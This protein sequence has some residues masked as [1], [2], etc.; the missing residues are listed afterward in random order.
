MSP[1]KFYIIRIV[2]IL[3][4]IQ[5]SYAQFQK[6]R[7]VELKLN[8]HNLKTEEK[9]TLLLELS[10]LY[11]SNNSKK[12][13]SLSKQA[14]E[15]AKQI[16][17]QKLI[18]NSYRAMSSYY[19]EKNDFDS[20]KYILNSA[21]KFI[22]K[23]AMCYFLLGQNQWFNGNED[24]C[25]YYY[26]LCEDECIKNNDKKTLAIACHSF[27]DYYRYNHKYDLAQKYIS[28]SI[29]ILEKINC[30]SDLATAYNIQAEIYRV[31]AIYP[32]AIKTYLQTIKIAYQIQDS[33]R[34]GYCI[35]RIGYIHYMQDEFIF[36]EV[37]LK[38]ALTISEK[39]NSKNLSLFCLKTLT[40]L[41]SNQNNAVQCK[42]YATKC[43][44]AG[45]KLKDITAQSLAYSS[46]SNL[47]FKNNKTDSSLIFANKAYHIADSSGDKINKLNSLLNKIPIFIYQKKHNTVLKLCNEGIIIAKETETLESLKDLYRYQYQTYEKL[48]NKSMAFESLLKYKM[49]E[50]STKN[51]ETNLIAK[52]SQYEL[53]YLNKHLSDTLNFIT[54]FQ[55]QE[56]R[57][58]VEKQQG[59]FILITSLLIVVTLLCIMIIIWS[60]R[61][62]QKKLNI[63]LLQ[64]NNEKE[65]LLLEIH[66]RVKNSLQIVS[67][68][69]NL[70]KE[71]TNQN[72]PELINESQ[73]KISNIAIVH[74]LLYQSSSHN[75]INLNI[76]LNQLTEHLMA[77]F[78]DENK[79]ITIQKNISPIDISLKNSVPLALIINE[80]IINSLKY[81]FEKKETGE[82]SILATKEKGIIEIKI[83]DNGNGIDD[84]N[85]KNKGIGLTLIE[86][87]TKQLKGQ[88]KYGND[89]GCFFVISFFDPII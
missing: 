66:H 7:E 39:T 34:I 56:Q 16:N 83:Q 23:D 54:N 88:L 85:P 22:P 21:L 67:S 19:I 60:A 2:T 58:I 71:K 45:I 8:T 61:K 47:Y 12:A 70:Q 77:S 11:Y 49:Y 14:L 20:S 51:D 86:G 36:A 52:K 1:I 28:Q 75:Q 15:F 73:L 69:L 65:M 81:A 48:S 57:L 43:L 5:V 29:Q 87:F 78:Y 30:L 53:E 17:N 18:G 44:N 84:F 79:K 82:I 10:E 13:F 35:S 42:I 38:Q 26:K 31:K 3:L 41:Y 46:L 72:F 27:A 33:N 4:S 25:I 6:I 63:A 64:S 40:D 74:D 55:K 9:A 59:T 68:L 62:K 50:D 37:Y 76:Y 24:S 32:K 80:I 89:N